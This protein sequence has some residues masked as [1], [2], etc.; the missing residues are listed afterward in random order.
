MV[1]WS[2]FGMS[3]VS[4]M[5]FSSSRSDHR[6]CPAGG[7]EQARA[8]SRAST[9][10]VT[11]G[12]GTGGPPAHH[13]DQACPGSSPRRDRRPWPAGHPGEH[14]V[15]AVHL[16]VERGVGMAGSAPPSGHHR[17]HHENPTP[18]E[19]DRPVHP[20]H[21]TLDQ[22][23]EGLDQPSP[24]RRAVVTIRRGITRGT[25][26]RRH[27]ERT[28]R[29]WACVDDIVADATVIAVELVEYATRSTAGDVCLR[30]ELR[31]GKLA[32]A[33]HDKAS[34]PAPTIDARHTQPQLDLPMVERLAR[35]WGSAPAFPHGFVVW[36]TL[37]I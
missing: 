33:V 34:V 17:R 11:G 1:E 10:P 31:C 24:W 6:A 26:T 8:I 18:S 14:F 15:G 5:C 30:L 2:R 35:A 28:C 13:V 7:C 36:A 32:I 9:S 3:S 12:G 25:R 16:G 22:A 27:V 19:R 37:P 4:S 21:D 29:R 20:V 23:I